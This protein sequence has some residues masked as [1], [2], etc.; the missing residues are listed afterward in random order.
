MSKT[1]RPTLV[2]GPSPRPRQIEFG[3]RRR[4]SSVSVA[5]N[6]NAEYSRPRRD[7]IL[8]VVAGP[9]NRKD[10]PSMKILVTMAPAIDAFTSMYSP[11]RSAVT[12]MINSVRFLSVALSSRLSRHPSFRRRPGGV[13][14]KGGK[15]NDGRTASTNRSG[16]PAQLAATSTTGT[17]KSEQ[18]VCRFLSRTFMVS[19]A[20]L[21]DRRQART[22]RRQALV[23]VR[24]DAK[25]TELD[26]ERPSP[27][28]RT[29][30]IR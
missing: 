20:S 7:C 10:A 18:R 28:R 4:M 11:A 12:A 23:G 3:D 21:C 1:K 19:A 16:P 2:S 22:P 8:N 13:A 29:S 27:A 15:R 6:S 17:N 5:I 26:V 30:A 24:H 25:T 14:Q 9:P